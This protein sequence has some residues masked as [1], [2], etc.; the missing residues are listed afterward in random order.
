M[1][2]AETTLAV[3]LGAKEWPEFPQLEA[4]SAFERS[5][6]WVKKYLQSDAGLKLPTENVLDLFDDPRPPAELGMDILMFIK[7]RRRELKK[8]NRLLTDLIVYFVGHGDFVGER[9][10]YQ[11]FIRRTSNEAPRLTSFSIN[12]I[13][14]VLRE[15]AI[16]LRKYLIIDACYAAG[17]ARAFGSSPGKAMH[18]QMT[19]ALPARGLALLCSSSRKRRSKAMSGEE[20]TMFTGTL[21]R[22]LTRGYSSRKTDFTLRDIAIL[23]K[24][25]IRDRYS[26]RAVPPEVHSPVQHQGD[27]A[28][29]PIFPNPSADAIESGAP[30]GEGIDHEKARHRKTLEKPKIALRVSTKPREVKCGDEVKVTIT[31]RNDGA[32]DLHHVYIL[33]DSML[34]TDPF[35]LPA[36][37]GRRFTVRQTYDSGGEYT[38]TVKASCLTENNDFVEKMTEATVRVRKRSVRRRKPSRVS[39][40]PEKPIER[41][42]AKP[43]IP[44]RPLESPGLRSPSL[45]EMNQEWFNKK[46]GWPKKHE[47]TDAPAAPLET[48]K[49]S[50]KKGAI[51]ANSSLEW[52]PIEGA[53]GYILEKSVAREFLFP[54]VAFDGNATR[55]ELESG[56]P[57]FPLSWPT[58]PVASETR[59]ERQYGALK[60]PILLKSEQG[61]WWTSVEGAGR[62][63]L[64]ESST[65]AFRFPRDVYSGPDTSL[66]YT[67]WSTQ[68]LSTSVGGKYEFSLGPLRQTSVPTPKY[69]RVRAEVGGFG[70][71]TS[72]PS[73]LDTRVSPWSNV[74]TGE[75][76]VFYRVKAKAKA[77]A[78][79]PDSDWSNV[80]VVF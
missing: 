5:A 52:T 51:A 80:V 2:T 35:D 55:F 18:E 10:T 74:V 24:Q 17:A 66:S 31:L 1:L 68:S 63:V 53:S 29:I 36:G 79:N 23:T 8:A 44:K 28:D 39:P 37:K 40:T 58:L 21:L 65:E 78:A 12:E 56:R 60:A 34:V 62:Y 67:D 11:L 50:L 14:E 47:Q 49:L 13:A 71:F 43:R 48:P 72:L 27:V 4:S 22:L 77:R 15:S 42:P 30:Q 70:D 19:N 57:L 61:F 75:F 41:Y 20:H 59:S 69:L 73:I 3:I 32:S 26:D 25:I 46:Y 33:H 64:Q 45:Y 76:P 9:D 6:E 38:A 7:K 16:D 54:S